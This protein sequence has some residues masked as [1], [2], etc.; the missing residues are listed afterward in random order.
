MKHVIL[1]LVALLTVTSAS[2]AAEVSAE[3]KK[4]IDHLLAITNAEKTA[5]VM[6]AQ[7]PL[8]MKRSLSRL[9]PAI[10]DEII[11]ETIRI[12]KKRMLEERNIHRISYPIY[13]KHFT[14]EEI[15]ELTAFYKSPLGQKIST[16]MPVVAQEIMQ[17]TN[18]YSKSLQPEIQAAIKKIIEEKAVQ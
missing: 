9:D 1:I 10:A 18:A 6:L 2:H 16:K 11:Q 8:L 3:K 7:I 5:E 17:A 15:K 12:T 14:L 4:A 13:H